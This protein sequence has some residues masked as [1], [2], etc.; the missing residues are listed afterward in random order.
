[1]EAIVPSRSILLSGVVVACL[2]TITA[3]PLIPYPGLTWHDQQRLGQIL[4][5]ALACIGLAYC[6]PATKARCSVAT[7]LL[8][9]SLVL[10][11]LCSAG[12]SRLP[13]WALGELSL[14]IIG[15]GIGAFAHVLSRNA[16]Q[17]F[18]LVLG[19][20]VRVL[21]WGMVL[22]FYVSYF[23]ALMHR[24]LYFDPWS[25]L[26]GFSNPRHQGQFLTIMLPLLAAGYAT[27][28]DGLRY[29]KYLDIG[30]MVSISTM[31]CIAGTRGTVLAWLGAALIFGLIRGGARSLARQML[32]VVL[33]GL[34]LSWLM[35]ELVFWLSAQESTFRLS[36]AQV[37]GLSSR[38]LIWGEAIAMIIDHPWFGIG[39]MHFAA[40]NNAIAAHP[41]Q[42][43]LQIASEW[44]IPAFF[45]VLGSVV[46]WMQRSFRLAMRADFGEEASI[47]WC[48]LFSLS[49]A[50]VQS[51]V[52][53]VLVMPYPQIWLSILIGWAF[54]KFH[55]PVNGNQ[56]EVPLWIPK[57]FFFS[58][59]LFL[60]FLA[61]ISYQDLLGAPE[62][63]PGAPRFWCDGRID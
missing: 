62:L 38:E 45:L 46:Y 44:G 14:L 8:V 36:D 32:L 7:V 43:L 19:G 48:M 49:S 55:V 59:V 41:H 31:V 39:P 52:D 6:F 33:S 40:L 25:L 58:A 23:S 47:R 16:P 57:S 56:L 17:R 61:G 30:L 42:A 20:A 13:V 5:S 26:Y 37:F 50:F 27:R 3:L 2:L 4:L 21:L 9:S 12:L 63:C 29:P 24:E 34:F 54:T 11:G 15:I 60:L 51:M 18:D 22:Q 28:I 1:M 10:L 35:L 53:G